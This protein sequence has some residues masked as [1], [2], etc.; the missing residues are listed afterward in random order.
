MYFRDANGVILVCDITDYESFEGL[1]EWAKE[2]KKHGPGNLCV[3]IAANKSDMIDERKV[4]EEDLVDYA[5]E[6]DATVCYTSAL[7]DDGIEVIREIKYF[8]IFQLVLI[9]FFRICLLRL[10]RV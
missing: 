1:S 5:K 2:L 8:I 6:L 7:D 3:C 4:K 10:S 9:F